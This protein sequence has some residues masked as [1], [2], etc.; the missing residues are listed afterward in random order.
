MT[1][2]TKFMGLALSLAAV[3]VLGLTGCGGS[4]SQAPAGV[5]FN[6]KFIDAAVQGLSWECGTESGLTTST[7]GFGTCPAGSSVTFKI[8]DFV[9]GSATVNDSQNGY[10]TPSTIAEGEQVIDIAVILQSMDSDPSTGL[11][12][13]TPADALTFSNQVGDLLLADLTATGI[14]DELSQAGF[15][16]VVTRVDAEAH[17]SATEADIPNMPPIQGPTGSGGG[18]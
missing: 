16:P 1:T 17:L 18:N 2:K 6:G 5:A 13:I 12:V 10:F 9:L 14:V 7:G 15:S 8:G 3:S 11:I 4:K